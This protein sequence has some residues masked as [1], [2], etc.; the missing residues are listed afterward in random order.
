MPVALEVQY[1]LGDLKFSWDTEKYRRNVQKHGITFEEAATTWL[2]RNAIEEFDQAH[3]TRE[4]RWFR[5]GL[6][7]RGAL[8]V[9]WSAVLIRKGEEVIRIIGA[10]RVT[11]AEQLLY[12]ENAS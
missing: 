1:Q 9:T 4:D 5:I 7:L 3:S 2:D 10:R 6:S 8:L 12:E 11:T